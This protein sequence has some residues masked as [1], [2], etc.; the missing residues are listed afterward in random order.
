MDAQEIKQLKEL[1]D[2]YLSVYEAKK[3]DQD[4]KN[5]YITLGF[6]AKR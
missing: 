2:A 4:G 5:L 3:V 1:Q 6:W